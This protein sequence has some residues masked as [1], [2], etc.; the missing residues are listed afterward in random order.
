MALY[1]VVQL[2]T[3]YGSFEGTLIESAEEDF[4]TL[5]LKSGYNIL[6]QRKDIIARNILKRIEPKSKKKAQEKPAAVGL[7]TI[8]ILHTGGTVASKVDYATGAVTAR[9]TPEDI[10]AMFPE[11][12][13][14]ANIKSRLIRNMASDDMRFAHY[15]LMA[16]EIKKEVELGAEGIIITH[17]TDT[18]HYTAAALSFILEDLPVP[19]I[20]VGSQRSSDRGSSDA[21]MNLLCAV[22]VIVDTDF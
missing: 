19:V 14:Y 3:K 17:G 21:A 10:L 16:Q 2:R 4:I 1:D 6:L 11:M 15:N 5:K 12:Q 18:L 7:K 9:F 8:S 13:E 22:K 20:L